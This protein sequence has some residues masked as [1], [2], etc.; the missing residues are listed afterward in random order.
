VAHCQSGS[1][2]REEECGTLSIREPR[3]RGGM[4]HIVNQG[5]WEE[6]R[7]WHIVNQ[8]AQDRY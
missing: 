3:E 7:M 5:A 2:G 1:P 4:W 6:G 8:E